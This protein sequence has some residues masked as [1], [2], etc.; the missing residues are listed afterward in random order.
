MATT[1]DGPGGPTPRPTRGRIVVALDGSAAAEAILP[2]VVAMARRTGAKITLVRACA[3]TEQDDPI[4]GLARIGGPPPADDDSPWTG[5][6]RHAAERYMEDAVQRLH[7]EGVPVD[8]EI[9]DG[10]PGEAI[11]DEAEGLHADMVAMTT[12]GRTG[13]GKLVLGSVAAYVV[14]HATCPVLLTRAT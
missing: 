13:L 6:A 9:L 12:H 4:A 5:N 2:M 3:P 14:G 1:I 10:A 8:Y 11:V 7:A